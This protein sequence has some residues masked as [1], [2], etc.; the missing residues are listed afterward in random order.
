MD[1]IASVESFGFLDKTS[2]TFLGSLGKAGALFQAEDGDG[3]GDGYFL[4][5][6]IAFEPKGG[7]VGQME[8][9]AL[10]GIRGAPAH[11]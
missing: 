4:R 5:C 10:H 3:P 9:E 6:G 7:A 11:S 2:V 8:D 1:G